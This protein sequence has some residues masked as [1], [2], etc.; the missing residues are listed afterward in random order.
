MHVNDYELVDQEVVLEGRDLYWRMDIE[1]FE[2]LWS[3]S[4][5]NVL[6][7]RWLI[8]FLFIGVFFDQQN[9]VVSKFDDLHEFLA[10]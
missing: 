10:F 9:G 1:S 6:K 7:L 8:G 5:L 3:M 4:F 2:I